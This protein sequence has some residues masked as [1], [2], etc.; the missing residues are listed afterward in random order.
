[1]K[2]HK[3]MSMFNKSL[4][5]NKISPSSQAQ[6]LVD[7][8]KLTDQLDRLNMLHHLQERKWIFTLMQLKFKLWKARAKVTMTPTI[9][10]TTP[11]KCLMVDSLI[12][13]DL[14]EQILRH[15][16]IQL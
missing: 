16:V 6:M 12:M 7:L 10:L 15:Y 8:A 14:L 13:I 5:S 4:V 11:M 2:L 9:S 1:M 3:S